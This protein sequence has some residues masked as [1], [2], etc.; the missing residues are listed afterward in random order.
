M[1]MTPCPVR[2]RGQVFPSQKAAAAQLGVVPSAISNALRRNGHCDNVGTCPSLRNLN[3]ANAKAVPVSIGALRFRSHNAA[4][5]K[6]GVPRSLV[7]RF[8]AGVVSH[9]GR[10]RLIA[11]AMDYENRKGC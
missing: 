5:K 7:R 4:A 8:A 1:T 11:A 3:N 2:I 9:K 6:L 10:E